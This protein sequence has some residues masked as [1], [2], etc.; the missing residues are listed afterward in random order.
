MKNHIETV[1]PNSIPNHRIYSQAITG[2]S[3]GREEA[4]GLPWPTQRIYISLTIGSYGLKVLFYP[5]W[6]EADHSH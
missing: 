3:W 1:T 2:L 5:K 6:L 4:P